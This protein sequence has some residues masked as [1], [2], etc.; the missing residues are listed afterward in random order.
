MLAAAGAGVAAALSP[1][2]LPTF[3]T[4]LLIA[5]L[6]TA[7]AAAAAPPFS[8]SDKTYP[9]ADGAP[10]VNVK[11]LTNSQ[12]DRRVGGDPPELGRQGRARQ[13]LQAHRQRRLRW[14]R[15]RRDRQPLREREVRP[16]TPGFSSR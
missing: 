5:L 1:M 2:G 6:P 14:P 8:V 7:A 12:Q 15:P 10:D 3:I 9:G 16:P 11:V 13:G 4:A